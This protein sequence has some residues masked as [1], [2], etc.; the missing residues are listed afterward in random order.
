MPK[1]DCAADPTTRSPTVPL[2]GARTREDGVKRSVATTTGHI[3]QG[4]NPS[5]GFEYIP[6]GGTRL[7]PR[8]DPRVEL[9]GLEPLTPCMPCRCATSCATAPHDF[10]CGAP[11]EGTG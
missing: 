1:P 11:V 10:S 7:G 4:Q 5:E 8:L 9:R 2:R 3:R 6:R